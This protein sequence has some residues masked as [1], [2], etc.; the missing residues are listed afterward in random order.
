VASPPET[1]IATY[2]V[3]A[4]QE[5][6]FFELLRRHHPTLVEVGLATPQPPVVYRSLE[7]ERGPT[8]YEIFT[9]VDGDAARVAH[10]T[11]EVMRIWEAMGTM[12][13]ERDGRPKFEFPHV[14]RV[15]LG[16]PHA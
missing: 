1:V 16:P 11:P 8:V 3:R 2:R 6:A 5:D 4:D 7:G 12:V 13:E 10:E 9:W 14:A 15:E